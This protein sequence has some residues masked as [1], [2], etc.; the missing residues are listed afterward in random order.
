MANM[1]LTHNGKGT[2]AI[3]NPTSWSINERLTLMEL[4]WSQEDEA[5]TLHMENITTSN[6]SQMK[7][8]PT[9][10]QMIYTAGR[11]FG[12]VLTRGGVETASCRSAE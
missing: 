3:P 6:V 1:K 7:A 11:R 12:V 9:P 4:G 5:G 2:T 8:W 10:P